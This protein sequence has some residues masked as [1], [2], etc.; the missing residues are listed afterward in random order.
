[1]TKP[2]DDLRRIK[3]ELSI[4][5]TE[6]KRLKEQ[7]KKIL[8]ENKGLLKLVNSK[9]FKFAESIA[10]KYNYIFPEYT[11]RRKIVESA[12]SAINKRRAT[13]KRKL[14]EK[15][16][17]II[18]KISEKHQ[19][20]IVLNSIPWDT[21]LKQRP[22][23]FANEFTKLGY[24]VIY[25]EESSLTDFRI[26]N[27]NLI[28]TNN[29]K[30]LDKIPKDKKLFF[31]TPNNMP[32][33]LNILKSIKEKGFRIIYDYLDE[34]HEDISGDL[35]IQLK[36]WDNLKS[37]SPVLCLATANRLYED[38]RNHLGSK[39]NIILAKNAVNT[40]HFNY[41]KHKD[42]SIPADIKKIVSKEKP[43]IGF[44]GALAPWIDFKLINEIAAK[45]P[46][47]EILLIGIN[48]NGAAKALGKY[49]NLHNIGP[50]D[51]EELPSYAKYFSCAIIPF[52]KGEIAK[53]TSP[54]KL[55]EYM[56]AGLP[57]VCTKD[58]E[59]CKGYD[60]VY[61]AKNNSEFIDYLN[62]AILESK[63]EDIKNQLLNQA[64]ENTWTQRVKDI[65]KAISSQ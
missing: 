9:R 22:H 39:T 3:K 37:L 58:L 33:S 2:T 35:S 49:K 51:Y 11:K 25:L 59:E 48:Y 61:V 4:A 64:E 19:K 46:E 28:T 52:K 62:Q 6:I 20:I 10:T 63:D 17:K 45:K 26:I 27:D 14:I 34:F 57:T 41:Q 50:K 16:Q 44:Y 56:A 13:K 40:D 65:D 15:Q 53:A 47:Y 54:V 30:L 32:T 7:N 31:L 21:K 5:K 12:S 55:F 29:Y 38:L 23:H 8:L 24:F 43:I 36:V 18:N 1:M 42:F 60:H